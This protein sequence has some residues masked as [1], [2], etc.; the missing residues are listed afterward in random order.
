M[1]DVAAAVPPDLAPGRAAQDFLIGGDPL[2]A[3][4]GQQRDQGLTDRALAGPHAPRRRSE[5]PQVAFHGAADMDLGVL[6][7]TLAIGWQ[8]HVGHRLTRELLV[9]QQGEDGVIIGRRGQLDLPTPSQG[10]VQGDDL[11]EQFPLLL[12]QPL[13]LILGVVPS[14]GL[15]LGEFPV[16]LEEQG[17]DPGQV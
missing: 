1:A 2:D 5:S 13:L 15:E 9:Q 12:Q 11:G 14:L 6:G 16:F 8:G 4:P 17:V 10:P 3:M 7:I